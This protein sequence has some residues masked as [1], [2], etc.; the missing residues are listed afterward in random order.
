[1]KPQE[2]S[3]LLELLAGFELAIYR[4]NELRD[5]DY[6]LLKAMRDKRKELRDKLKG[7]LYG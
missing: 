7:L 1:M 6:K 2:I 3:E 4:E 5:P